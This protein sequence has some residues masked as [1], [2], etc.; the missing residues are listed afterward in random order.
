MERL[1]SEE[2]ENIGN[3]KRGIGVVKILEKEKGNSV[4]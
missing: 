2:R 1:F 4:S 3:N